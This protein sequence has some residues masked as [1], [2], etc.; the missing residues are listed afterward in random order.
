MP[1]YAVLAWTIKEKHEN[2]S[3]PRSSQTVNQIK[4]RKMDQTTKEIVFV[5]ERKCR[6]RTL[7]NGRRNHLTCVMIGL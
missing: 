1:D 2:A 4:R 5:Q 6:W 7:E 3:Y